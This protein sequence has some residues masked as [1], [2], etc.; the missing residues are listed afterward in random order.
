MI[1]KYS[2]LTGAKYFSSGGLQNYLV[3]VSIRHVEFLTN[4]CKVRSWQVKGM[5]EESIKNSHTSD[6]SFAPDLIDGYP[7][8]K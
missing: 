1:N 2:I 8:K 7:I 5:P 6:I 3:A 4:D